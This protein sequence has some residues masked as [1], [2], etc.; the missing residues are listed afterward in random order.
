MARLCRRYLTAAERLRRNQVNPVTMRNPVIR[1]FEARWFTGK[2]SPSPSHKPS[3]KAGGKP[4]SKP[5]PKPSPWWKRENGPSHKPSAKPSPKPSS[6]Y[7]PVPSQKLAA[8][9]CSYSG[10]Q[11]DTDYCREESTIDGC[12][13]YSYDVTKTTLELT[14]GNEFE[15]DGYV[16]FS[17]I[18]LNE[19]KGWGSAA[20]PDPE[21]KPV[22]AKIEF[23]AKQ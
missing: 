17:Y 13:H 19:Y 20:T 18:P 23:G 22:K 6:K 12:T 9:V 7:S 14:K 21:W 15:K 5:S 16:Q 8:P 3:A 11:A 2:P 10:K 1:F 4:S